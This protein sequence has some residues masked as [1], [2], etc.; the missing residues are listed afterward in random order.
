MVAPTVLFWPESILWIA[1]MSIFSIVL[2]S[3]N[4]WRTE[5]AKEAA[6][7]AGKEV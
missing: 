7:K 3:F 4:L 6:E 5:R 1:F 2:S